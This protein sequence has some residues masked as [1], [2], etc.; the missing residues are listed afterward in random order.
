[1]YKIYRMH[2]IYVCYNRS[3]VKQ[4]F[5]HSAFFGR[6]RN[7]L[8]IWRD[9]PQWNADRSPNR[10]DTQESS[11]AADNRGRLSPNSPVWP[12]DQTNIRNTKP[13]LVNLQTQ[14][15]VFVKGLYRDKPTPTRALI[16][17]E[18]SLTQ[19]RPFPVGSYRAMCIHKKVQHH[20]GIKHWYTRIYQ[21]WII[22]PWYLW[23]TL[24]NMQ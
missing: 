19:P 3:V 14:Y 11:R 21:L 7:F 24:F 10:S 12:R 6:T 17:H 4:L 20:S 16:R 15:W 23:K 22:V 13:P 1:M 8:D 5:C 2:C 18:R 9:I